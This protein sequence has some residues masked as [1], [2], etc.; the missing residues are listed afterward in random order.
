[1]GT[2]AGVVLGPEVLQVIEPGRLGDERAILE[3]LARV[4]L[5]VSLVAA[6]LQIRSHDLRANGL[7]ATVLLTVVMVAM[8]AVSTLG[9]WLLLGLPFWVAALIGAI[10]TPTDPVVASTLVTGRLAEGNLPR[11]VR[12]TLQ[13]ESGANDGLALAFVLLPAIVLT[14]PSGGAG[15]FPAEAAKQ[16]GLGVGVGIGLGAAVAAAVNRLGD[17]EELERSSF[18]AMAVALGLLALGSASFLGGTG[19]LAAFVAGVTASVR[20]EKRFSDELEAVQAGAER[21]IIVPVFVLFGA[22]IPWA[23]WEALGAGGLAFAAWS[24]LLRRPPAA[25]LA[26]GLIGTRRRPAA[27]LAWFGPIGVAAIYYSLF[28]ERYSPPSYEAVFGACTLAIAASVVVHSLTATPGVRAF[29]GHSS[30]TTLLHPLRKDV[31]AAP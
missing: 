11:W 10:V 6:A 23:Q 16:I 12:R 18:L 21:L 17:D 31:D 24:V 1:M 22:M 29:A 20:L 28:V 19:V 26:L 4:T 13:L 3:Q 5:A 30:L 2:V 15:A 7:R 14:S 27:F 9:A 8:W 25:T